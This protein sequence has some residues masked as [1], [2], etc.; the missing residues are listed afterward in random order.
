VAQLEPASQ[1]ARLSETAIAFAG[2]GR[3]SNETDIA[4]AGA[5]WAFWVRFSV[6]EVMVVSMVAVWGRAE[7]MVVSMVAVQGRAVVLL[8]SMPPC[9]R[10]SCAI[11]FALRGL[12]CA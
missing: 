4:F 7:A 5:K 2:G 6:A 12:M 8:V 9:C 10:A 1:A 11:K 3:A